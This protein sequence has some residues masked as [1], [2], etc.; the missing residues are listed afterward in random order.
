MMRDEQHSFTR[1]VD[2]SMQQ[3]QDL[4][5]LIISCLMVV[6]VHPGRQFPIFVSLASGYFY[7]SNKPDAFSYYRA[8]TLVPFPKHFVI[9]FNTLQQLELEPREYMASK[10]IE[11]IIHYVS[12][13]ASTIM[14]SGKT[15]FHVVTTPKER[16]RSN[17]LSLQREAR[18]QFYQHIFFPRGTNFNP[19]RT[20]LPFSAPFFL[21]FSL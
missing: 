5:I 21:S 13:I 18:F 10:V 2:C 20:I 3:S 6:V 11:V 14:V 12:S 7:R 4:S 17:C 1:R 15:S 9:R 19:A 8:G 16:S